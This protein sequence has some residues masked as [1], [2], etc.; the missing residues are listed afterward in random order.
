MASKKCA[1]LAC[2]MPEQP[3]RGKGV[4]QASQVAAFQGLHH[5]GRVADGAAGIVDQPGA[6]LHLPDRL[7]VEH[8]P[9]QT[10]ATH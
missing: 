7:L 2:V 3:I 9:A 1:L 10:P 8:V 5:S 4:R 6:L